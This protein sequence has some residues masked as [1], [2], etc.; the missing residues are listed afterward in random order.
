MFL[1]RLGRINWMH[2][3]GSAAVAAYEQAVAL[4]ADRPPSV[5]QAFTLSALGQSLMLR[6]RFREAEAVLQRAIAVSGAVGAPATEGH[7]LC[8]LGPALVGVGRGEEGLAE[9]YRAQ[10]LCRAYGPTEDM[11]RTFVNLVHSLCV[12]GRYDEAVRAAAEGLAH[13]E[14]TGH[15]RQ[16]GAAI[17]ANLIM[18]LFLAGR[19]PE[20][21]RAK[22]AFELHVPEP[23][24]YLEMRWLSLLLGQ[25]RYSQARPIIER[26]LKATTDARD[27]QFRQMPAG[28]SGRGLYS[29][30]TAMTSTTARTPA[31]SPCRSRLIGSTR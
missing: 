24:A 14:A 22:A 17:T 10:P 19:W 28:Y 25:G 23:G 9:I 3:R 16:A 2:L 8:S 4:L 26:L 27:V 6:D 30:P 31:R 29:Q 13:A 12:C 18:A 21:E 7:A 5:E 20:A 15:L 1:E 11:S